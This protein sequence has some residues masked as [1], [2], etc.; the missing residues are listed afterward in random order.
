MLVTTLSVCIYMLKELIFVIRA[1]ALELANRGYWD[2]TLE[3]KA[4]AKA[5]A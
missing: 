5:K 3:C 4:K 2:V 1:G